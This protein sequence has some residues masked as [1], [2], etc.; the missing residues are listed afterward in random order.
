MGHPV[1]IFFRYKTHKKNYCDHFM[2]FLYRKNIE[3]IFP[4][5]SKSLDFLKTFMTLQI[6][7]FQNLPKSGAKCDLQKLFIYV[8]YPKNILTVKS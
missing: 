2:K 8:L 1:N 4:S 6:K 3:Y 5:L 7:D